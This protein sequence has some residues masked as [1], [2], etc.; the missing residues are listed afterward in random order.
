MGSSSNDMQDQSLDKFED[1]PHRRFNILTGEWV[2]VSAHRSKRPWNGQM[3]AKDTEQLN[4]HD[5]GCYLC[6]GN[7]RVSGIQ[8][9]KCLYF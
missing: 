6:P 8:N 5:A 9:P 4:K 3:E 2:L 1:T 7:T